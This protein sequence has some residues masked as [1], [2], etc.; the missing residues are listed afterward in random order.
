MLLQQLLFELLNHTL[1]SFFLFIYT[2][3][4]N[5]SESVDAKVFL[6][7]FKFSA[8]TDQCMKA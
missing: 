6:F 5:H 8:F 7:S 4:F 1:I 3:E 2:Q